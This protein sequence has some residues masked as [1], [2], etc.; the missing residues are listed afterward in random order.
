MI[1]A[2]IIHLYKY[3]YLIEQRFLGLLRVNLHVASNEKIST[4]YVLSKQQLPLQV[5]AL[6]L[7]GV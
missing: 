3:C 1:C 2:T 5:V 7:S 6:K 4:F